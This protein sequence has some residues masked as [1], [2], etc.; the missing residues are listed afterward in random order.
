M[1]AIVTGA[2]GLIG[3]RFVELFGSSFEELYQ[4]GRSQAEINAGWI[5]YNLSSGLPLN[6]PEVDAI[7]HFA[8]QTSAY[9]SRGDVFGDLGTNLTGFV[10]LLEAASKQKRPPFVVLAGTATQMGFT[11]AKEGVSESPCN[12]PM[13]F[14]DISKLA[15][16]NYLLQFVREGWLRGCSLRLCNV[17]GGTRAGQNNDRGV[18]DKVFQRAIQG[19]PVSIFG[20]GE[21]LRDYIHIDDVVTAFYSSWKHCEQV[22]GR[23]F[24]IGTGTGVTLKDAFHLV[25]KL[26]NQASGRAVKLSQVEPPQDLSLIELRSFIAD[27]TKFREATGWAPKY[28]LEEGIRFSYRNF[29]NEAV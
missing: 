8:G 19:E 28:S 9:T 6:L 23:F 11:D 1:K 17:Y 5:E 26:A 16:E 2:S 25:V 10:R 7:F 12:N 4:L 14:Y 22:D 21:Y 29:F 20:S 24:N 18:I 13:T 3:A 27:N 15:A